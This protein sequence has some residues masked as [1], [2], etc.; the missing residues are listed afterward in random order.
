M[1][2]LTYVGSLDE[3]LRPH[4]FVRDGDDWVRIRGDYWECVNLQRSVGC[5]V[6]VN[7][8]KKDVATERLLRS[9]PTKANLLYPP[10]QER[11]GLLASRFDKWWRNDPNGPNEAADLMFR[12]GLP[13]FDVV[14]TLEDQIKHWYQF[15]TGD[16]W[17]FAPA[18]IGR[19]VALY[20]MGRMDEALAVL[21]H[22]IPR[23][24]IASGVAAVAALRYWMQA[25]P[26]PTAD[27]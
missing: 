1:T 17:Y 4:G 23:T 10:E 14:Q 25:Q 11:L 24:A 12:Y 8:L 9:I 21:G 19:A 3:V 20:R 5:G 18:I 16:G 2:K 13:W 22:R 6:T 15:G 7:V 27:R 26:S